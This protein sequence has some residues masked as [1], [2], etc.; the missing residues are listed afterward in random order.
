MKHT[1]IWNVKNVNNKT[2]EYM[3]TKIKQKILSTLEIPEN[4]KKQNLKITV[5]K[6]TDEPT[7]NY[8]IAGKILTGSGKFLAEYKLQSNPAVEEDM[9]LLSY[10]NTLQF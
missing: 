2:K 5:H 3:E 9:V 8:Y 1:F 7:K 10:R 6:N 4:C